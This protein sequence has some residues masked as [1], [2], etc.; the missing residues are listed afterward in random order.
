METIDDGLLL[1]KSSGL[2]TYD[3]LY[4]VNAYIARFIVSM[5]NYNW[6]SINYID[7]F[8]GPGKNLLPDKR[9]ILGSPLLALSQK[10]P[11]DHYFFSD[12]D[13]ENIEA[14]K[15]RCA[16]FPN[17]FSKI[18]FEVKDANKTVKNVVNT[19]SDINKFTSEKWS[20][21]NLALLDPEGLELHWD[22]VALLASLRTD[23]IIYYPQMGI[24][25]EAKLEIQQPSPTKIDVFFGDTE[26]RHIYQQYQHREVNFLHRTL[27]DYYKNKL[28]MFGYKVDDPLAEP[29]F[30]NSKDAWLYRLLF[31]C[32]H[33]L[34]NKFWTDITKNLPS[35]QLRLM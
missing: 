8:A 31:V 2:W 18:T 17:E 12:L 27:L 7:L 16:I 6:R 21:L 32:K 29:V 1:R 10:Q 14:L 23:M 34:G 3:K 4:Y 9:I 20:S 11:F 35:G 28:A 26:W 13:D 24:T 5:R 25:R 15:K 30:T 19:I 22:T 33:P